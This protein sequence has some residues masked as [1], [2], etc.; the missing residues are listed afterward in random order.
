[1]KYNI[2][3]EFRKYLLNKLGNKNTADRYY[4]AVSKCF[5]GLQFDNLSDISKEFLEDSLKH[6]KGKTEF[7]ALKNGLLHLHEFD[8][9][10]SIPEDD[11]LNRLG[12]NKLRGTK[13]T[14]KDIYPNIVKR[15]INSIKEKKFKLGFRLMLLSG[16]RVSELASLSKNDIQ[17]KDGIIGINLE[18]GKGGKSGKIRCDSDDYLAGAL[19]EYLDSIEDDNKKLFYSAKTMK[20]KALELGIEC[21]DLRRIAAINHR[22]RLKDDGIA[23]QEANEDTRKY[24]RHER[25]ST[26]KRYLFNRKL[27][28]KSN[29]AFEVSSEIANNEFY[30]KFDDEEKKIYQSAIDNESEI[31]KFI[32][33]ITKN[34]GGTLSGLENRLK[35]P[36]SIYEKAHCREENTK[37][38]DMSDLIRYTGI[39][40]SD[41]LPEAIKE[42]FEKIKRKGY[43]I[44]KVK[45]YWNEPDDPYNGVNVTV[46][47]DKNKVFEIQYHTQESFEIK[48]ELHK[49]YEKS[50]K[51]SRKSKKRQ[52]YIEEMFN[53]SKNIKIPLGIEKIKSMR[54]S[55]K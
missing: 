24:L 18:K 39:Y 20:N 43:E 2:L 38:E 32:K 19:S 55:K 5:K 44:V 46:K 25:F 37:V 31:T 23:V 10:F 15:K 26:T 54:R 28:F 16:L 51:L 47:T 4:F 14:S 41:S 36:E 7:S 27:K 6:I 8:N 30:R 52:E 29:T 45:N 48:E 17:I 42:N 40:D 50:R 1:M 34:T 22:N 35:T 49:I 3:S 53:L 9:A 33:R 13:R 12:E 21:H 11:V